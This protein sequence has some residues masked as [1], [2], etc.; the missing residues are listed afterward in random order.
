VVFFFAGE[1]APVASCC[2]TVDVGSEKSHM[3]GLVC[4]TRVGRGRAE[5]NMLCQ[6]GRLA[7]G[8]EKEGSAGLV[9][10]C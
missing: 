7:M 1:L 3:V 6:D 5:S 4:V 8:G 2:A 9:L 10:W